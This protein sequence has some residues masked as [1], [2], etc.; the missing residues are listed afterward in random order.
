MTTKETETS[1]KRPIHGQRVPPPPFRSGSP[2]PLPK[3]IPFPPPRLE[4]RGLATTPFSPPLSLP[5]LPQLFPLPALSLF[6]P[7]SVKK[8]LTLLGQIRRERRGGEGGGM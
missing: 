8:S 2:S 7:Q 3:R 5:I 4:P 6:S 1:A